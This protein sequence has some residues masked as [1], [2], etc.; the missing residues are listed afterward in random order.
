MSH[1]QEFFLNIFQDERGQDLIEYALVAA[2][3]GLAAMTTMRGLAATIATALGN[4][5]TRL[6]TA[7]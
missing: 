4:I 6:T 7:V 5:G 1:R 2:L 3:V